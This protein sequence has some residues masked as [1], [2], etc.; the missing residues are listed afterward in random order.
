MDELTLRGSYMNA[1][2]FV[3]KNNELLHLNTSTL[4]LMKRASDA[5]DWT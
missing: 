4:D 1:Y 2:E 5:C 3:V